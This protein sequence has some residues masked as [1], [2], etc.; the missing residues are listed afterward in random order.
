MARRFGGGLWQFCFVKMIRV[1]KRVR[2]QAMR[3]RM[4]RAG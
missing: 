4:D 2:A 1:E 3:L